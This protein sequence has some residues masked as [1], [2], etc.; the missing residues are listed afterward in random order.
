[1]LARPEAGRLLEGGEAPRTVGPENASGP[2]VFVAGLWRRLA[3]VVLDA[4]CL[5]PVFFLV[6]WIAFGI[7]GARLPSKIE[8]RLE[9]VLELFLGGGTLLYSLLALGILLLLIYGFL[10]TA[11]LGATPGLRL[12]GLRVINGYGEPPEWWRAVLRGFGLLT[13]G[14]L[15]GL[16][17]L[18]IGFDRS[19]RGLHDWIAGTYVVRRQAR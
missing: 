18:W 10:F 12:L 19:K 16:G 8:P 4:A 6:A 1:M 5:V 9:A 2:T 14:I 15:L 7:S 11:T 17:F 3:A 13:S